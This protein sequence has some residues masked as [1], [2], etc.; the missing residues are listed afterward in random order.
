MGK[1]PESGPEHHLGT[2]HTEKSR[3]KPSQEGAVRA[4]LGLTGC[5]ETGA[6]RATDRQA[7][8]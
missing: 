5:A 6:E 8:W 7:S 2:E 4:T 1:R 3:R